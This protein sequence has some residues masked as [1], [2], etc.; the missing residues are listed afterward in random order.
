M[1]QLRTITL[2]SVVGALTVCLAAC[3]PGNPT[4]RSSP[5]PPGSSPAILASTSGSPTDSGGNPGT[6]TTVGTGRV[7]GT[8]DTLTIA[9]GVTTTAPHAAAALDQNNALASKVQQ[10]LSRD[11][12]ATKDIQTADLSLQEA[13]PPSDGY[14]ASDDV[15][16]TVRDL[17]SAG[18]VIDD[19]LA[20]AGDAGR[21]QMVD[22]S[23]SD[24]DPYLASARESAVAA[25][26]AEAQQLATG[27][28]EHLG[29]L[30]SIT[31]QP[32]NIS[33]QPVFAQLGAAAASGGPVPVQP[34]TQMVTVSVT[35]V[36][37]IA[38]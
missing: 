28:G 32:S 37:A 35:T 5:Q 10:A 8:P 16:A 36:W 29:A 34:G 30:V 23:L 14:Q 15:T 7:T 9:I 2:I 12:V 17:H 18:T 13:Y 31:D 6:I 21:L 25:A 24:S 19:A 22:F 1:T 20:A 27:A 11:G 4:V 3:G 33:P 38:P 26:K